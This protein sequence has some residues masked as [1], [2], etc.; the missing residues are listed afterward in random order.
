MDNLLDTQIVAKMCLAADSYLRLNHDILHCCHRVMTWASSYCRMPTSVIA[1]T[2]LARLTPSCCPLHTTQ[3]DGRPEC[4]SQQRAVL[5]VAAMCQSA[6]PPP[7]DTL[8][9][10]LEALRTAESG[11]AKSRTGG[12]YAFVTFDATFKLFTDTVAAKHSAASWRLATAACL[13]TSDVLARAQQCLHGNVRG[14]ALKQSEDAVALAARGPLAGA[15]V[16][17]LDATRAQASTAGG[18]SLLF[19]VP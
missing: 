8:A 15:L 18:S 2:M 19:S 10:A 17:V 1:V 13:A 3:S 14:P 11:I 9:A 16:A 4:T 6:S 5:E 12:G 7:F